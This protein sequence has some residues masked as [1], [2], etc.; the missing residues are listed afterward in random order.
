[1]D[2]KFGLSGRLRLQHVRAG[3]IVN[4]IDKSNTIMDIGRSCMAAMLGSDIASPVAFD[5]IGI[6]TSGLTAAVTQSTLGSEQVRVGTTSAL[7]TSGVSND[8]ARFI[9]SFAI[10]G[11]LSIQEA[12]IFNATSAGSMLCR[13]TFTTI[14]VVSGDA[15]NATWDVTV[16]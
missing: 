12:G 10:S 9:G 4:D 8:T 7:A 14:S 2:E 16:A 11:T 6:G 15:I 1:M 13:T 3:C 5:F